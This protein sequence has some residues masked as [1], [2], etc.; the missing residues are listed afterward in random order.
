MK[1]SILSFNPSLEQSN[2]NVRTICE[3]LGISGVVRAL[4]EKEDKQAMVRPVSKK[5]KKK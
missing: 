4:I 1:K 2:E 5:R 3:A